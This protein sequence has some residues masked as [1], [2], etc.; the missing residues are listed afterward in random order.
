MKYFFR[1]TNLTNKYKTYPHGFIG[2]KAVHVV[3]APKTPWGKELEQ[4]NFDWCFH[5]NNIVGSQTKTVQRHKRTCEWK[6]LIHKEMCTCELCTVKWINS[7]Y[8]KL[9]TFKFRFLQGN[10]IRIGI[11]GRQSRS[12]NLSFSEDL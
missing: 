3:C 8:V 9:I 12:L 6:G 1:I 5:K 11:K 10:V 4:V 2:L 7:A